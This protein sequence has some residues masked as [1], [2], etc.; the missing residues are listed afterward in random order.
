MGDRNVPK[1][2]ELP[3]NVRALLLAKPGMEMGAQK[4]ANIHQLAKMRGI[5]VNSL[6]PSIC[7]RSEQQVC[8]IPV[9][10]K[11]LHLGQD[12]GNA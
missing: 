1:F 11:A 8:A 2:E 6:W 3:G 12:L 5:D 10:I 9:A 7:L 4:A